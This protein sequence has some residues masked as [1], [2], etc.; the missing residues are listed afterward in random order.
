MPASTATTTAIGALAAAA[1]AAGVAAMAPFD[2][3][4][5]ER[6]GT[7]DGLRPGKFASQ[8]RKH[9]YQIP[10]NPKGLLLVTPGCARWGPGFWPYDPSSCPECVGLTE[11]VCHTKQALARG[12]A[13]LVGWPVDRA[14]PGQYCWSAKDDVPGIVRVLEDFV[15]Q[16][17]LAG[18]PIYTMGASS[19]GSI[20]L[21]MPSLL[22]KHGTKGLKISGVVA[23]VSTTRGVDDIAKGLKDLPPI[24]WVVM[25]PDEQ[26]RA[27]QHAADYQRL[28]GK[29]AVVVSPPRPVTDS[30]FSDRSPVITPAQS[31]QLVGALKRSGV[32]GNDGKFTRDFKK[33]KSWVGQVQRSV[34]WIKSSPAY[35]LGPTKSSAILQAMLVA[36]AHHEH[37]CDY[38]TAAFA[39]FEARGAGSFDSFVAKY[40]V[41]KPSALTMT[42]GPGDGSE[43]GPAAASSPRP[44][45]SSHRFQFG[46]VDPPDD[47]PPEP[48]E[49]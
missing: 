16:F 30:Y 11:D 37:V 34:P 27:R 40:R 46:P 31:A 26:G 22:A 33:D 49:G 29:A 48:D 41:T 20:A 12:Y 21:L 14:F 28:G 18:K 32:L 47:P 1:V 43:S 9:Y 15:A 38:L 4:R 6:F 24:V 42:A 44:L 19:G 36:E 35:A 13:I 23:E 25:K 8:G 45:L 5:V 10:P 2:H 3:R 17:N 7:N 39:W